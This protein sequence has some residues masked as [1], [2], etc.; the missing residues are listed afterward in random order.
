M[1]FFLVKL[2]KVPFLKF[3]ISYNTLNDCNNFK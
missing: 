3:K 2:K 1:K